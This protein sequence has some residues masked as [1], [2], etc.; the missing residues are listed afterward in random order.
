MRLPALRGAG[1]TGRHLE[2]VNR[3]HG[4]PSNGVQRALEPANMPNPRPNSM[5]IVPADHSSALFCC[6]QVGYGAR[7]RRPR[8]RLL[9]TGPGWSGGRAWPPTRGMCWP[10]GSP[11]ARFRELASWTHS[12]A[13]WRGL[14]HTRTTG[15]GDFSVGSELPGTVSWRSGEVLEQVRPQNSH[16]SVQYAARVGLSIWSRL[17]YTISNFVGKKLSNIFELKT[18]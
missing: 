9:G 8:A 7:P 6:S 4:G 14:A 11:R 10:L 3:C 1:P 18:A 17:L 13:V 16:F 15:P 2:G 5:H 12:T